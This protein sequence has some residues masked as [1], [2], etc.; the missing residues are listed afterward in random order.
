V[1]VPPQVEGHAYSTPSVILLGH[2]HPKHDEKAL[3][4]N[5]M[6]APAIPAYD[7]LVQRMECLHDTVACF[8]VDPFPAP[9]HH[10]DRIAEDGNELTFAT[11]TRNHRRACKR[12]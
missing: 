9:C 12:W 10:T 6:Q 5:G 8:N 4:D 7:V 1:H 2:W 3:I 11:T